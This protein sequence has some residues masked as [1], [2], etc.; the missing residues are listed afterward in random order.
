MSLLIQ[1]RTGHILL[2]A[3]LHRFKKANFPFC[4]SCYTKGVEVKETVHHFIFECPKHQSI[5]TDM[6]KGMRR[7]ATSMWSMM[8]NVTT[9]KALLKYIGKTWRFQATMGN[10][11]LESQTNT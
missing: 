11:Y 7:G 2:N 8:E 6:K 1:L 9:I 3:Y 5:R 10:I 4:E